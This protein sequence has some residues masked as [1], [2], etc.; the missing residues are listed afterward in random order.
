M[1]GDGGVADLVVPLGYRR[2]PRQPER[3]RL[4]AILADLPEVVQNAVNPRS[5]G[6][7]QRG[8]AQEFFAGAVVRHGA[9]GRQDEFA[10]GRRPRGAALRFEFF[11]GE[12]AI[13]QLVDSTGDGRGE[14]FADVGD[15]DFA[16]VRR[17]VEYGRREVSEQIQIA[18]F[19][20]RVQEVEPAA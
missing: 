16:H 18:G 5:S 13:V 10:S 15:R 1:D 14:R 7:Q 19:D 3:A 2:L 8:Q 9:A 12:R 17:V 20:V 11:G 6:L 4:T